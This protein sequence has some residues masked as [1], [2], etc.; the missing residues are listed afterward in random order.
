MVDFFS[1]FLASN[2]SMYLA[3]LNTNKGKERR[4]RKGKEREGEGR[5]GEERKGEKEMK[6]DPSPSNN[7]CNIGCYFRV[8]RNGTHIA[9]RTFPIIEHNP[10]I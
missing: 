1:L 4:G 5:R 8:L 2:I 3:E 7:S 10:N 6:Y 9:S